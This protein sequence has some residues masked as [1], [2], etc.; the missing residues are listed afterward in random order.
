MSNLNTDTLLLTQ[1]L[2]EILKDQTSLIY[3]TGQVAVGQTTLARQLGRELKLPV[4]SQEVLYEAVMGP[5]FI[6]GVHEAAVNWLSDMIG[7]HLLSR[8]SVVFDAQ[9]YSAAVRSQYLNVTA[10]LGIPTYCVWTQCE[11]PL[12]SLIIKQKGYPLDVVRAA[13]TIFDPPQT[14]EGFRFVT[15]HMTEPPSLTPTP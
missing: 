13:N 8:R 1:V 2:H 9:T 10:G 5:T 14:Q 15:C 6:T 4:V 12:R 3:L 7:Y 11:E